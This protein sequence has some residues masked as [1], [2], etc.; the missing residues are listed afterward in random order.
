[1][2]SLSALRSRRHHRLGL[3]AALI[4][5][6]ALGACDQGNGDAGKGRAGGGLQL[7]NVL[8]L[9]IGMNADQ[10]LDG[11]SHEEVQAQLSSLETGYRQIH[12]STHFQFSL[13][14]EAE[15]H[16]AIR[17]RNQ[18]G[19]GPDLLL[20]NGTT[21]LKLLAQGLV[22]PFPATSADLNLF[23]AR[24]LGRLRDRRGQLAGLPVLVQNQVA[25][26]NRQR[27][28]QPPRTVQELL[29]VGASG[30]PIGLSADVINLYW[31]AGSL[32]ATGSINRLLSGQTATAQDRQQL[33]NWLSWLQ[34]ANNQLWVTFYP[35]QQTVITEFLAGR[36]DWMPCNSL[37]LPRLR[38]HLGQ[39]LGVSALPSGAGGDASPVNRLRVL[40]L[41]H[42]SSASGRQRAL[43]FVR[44]STNP[45]IQRLL[46]LGSQTVLPANRFVKVPVQSSEVLQALE[47]AN[48]QGQVV[49][50][51]LQSLAD[52]NQQI[53]KAQAVITPLLFGAMKPER[54]A[55]QLIAL[56]QKHR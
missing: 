2:G 22:D 1:M 20:L 40:A 50:Q 19:I 21:A 24:D 44:Y 14:P 33:L 46:T 13:Y 6:L 51:G 15:L 31:S 42:S 32:G 45:L 36:L 47:T 43:T 11:R 34:D 5:S 37:T 28:P 30:H 27:L 9:A 10:V 35:S 54:A 39:Q 29:A 25:C 12:P 48:Q 56:L 55:D 8:Y 16:S 26:F 49:G 7:P 18:A 38:Q 23:R 4:S 41:G 17:Q 52:N 3:A 53:A